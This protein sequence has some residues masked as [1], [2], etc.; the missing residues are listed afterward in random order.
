MD[1]L[2][3][4]NFK[5]FGSRQVIPLA[6]I[7]LIF[8]ANS[9]GKSSIIQSLLLLK[10]T[11]DEAESP[12]QL[13]VFR[14]ESVDVGS[15]QDLVF[16]HD[17]DRVVEI[18]ILNTRAKVKAVRPQRDKQP[19]LP[20]GV[21]GIGIKFGYEVPSRRPV[22]R[23]IPVYL[24]SAQEPA[25]E[26]S[27]SPGKPDLRRTVMGRSYVSES[28][29]SEVVS[30]SAFHT[31]IIINKDHEVWTTW[32]NDYR[33]QVMPQISSILDAIEDTVKNSKSLDVEGNSNAIATY[34]LYQLTALTEDEDLLEDA[35]SKKS[36][37]A[38]KRFEGILGEIKSKHSGYSFAEYLSDVAR[39]R[40]PNQVT[41]LKNY[42]LDSVNHDDRQS[43]WAALLFALQRI[44]EVSGDSTS[45]PDRLR[46]QLTFPDVAVLARRIAQEQRRD[47]ARMVYLGPLR[48]YPERQYIV[49][50]RQTTS[51]GKRGDFTPDILFANEAL[52]KRANDK[53][54]EFGF[55]YEL[56]MQELVPKDDP[57][58]RADVFSVRLIDSS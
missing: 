29:S 53:I 24:G 40:E 45:H 46:T 58:G 50:G 43:K 32:W 22:A 8:G 28:I 7:T 31:S 13:F 51:V 17:L 54:K 27:L 2:I 38:Q 35:A 12:K 23:T 11:L 18:S 44:Y 9:A 6:P 5:A 56:S 15:F 47:L 30:G 4:E 34:L 55:G 48:G 26:V 33:T 41:F 3:L 37:S 16:H 36:I 52:A 1:Q 39:D 10:Q 14:G 19:E 25:Y 21:G 20:S 57:D 49:G 42:L